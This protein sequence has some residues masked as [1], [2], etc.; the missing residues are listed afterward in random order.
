M[1][2]FGHSVYP[3]ND[4][5]SSSIQIAR[6]IIQHAEF[7]RE[8]TIRELRGVNKGAI[9]G[10]GWLV[11]GPLVQ[12][13]AYVVIVSFV[14]GQRLNE[15]SGSLDYALYVLTGMIPWQL[16]QLGLTKAPSLVRDRI[17]IVKQIAYPIET[18][19]ITTI[20]M[21]ALAAMVSLAVCL[22]GL[23]VSRQLQLSILLLPV[24]TVLLFVFLIGVSWIFMIGA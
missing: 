11:I 2:T 3:V 21:G 4:M 13:T 22:V 15:E 24:P 12:V 1:Q 20:A 14:F 19:P 10:I 17:E 16:T 18:L 8:M 7:T 5:F 23:L 6:S 9:L